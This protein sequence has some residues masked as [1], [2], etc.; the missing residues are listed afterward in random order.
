MHYLKDKGKAGNNNKIPDTVPGGPFAIL[1][2][3]L[4][5]EI[6]NQ[7][8]ANRVDDLPNQESE[9]CGLSF[10]DCYQKVER[11]TMWSGRKVLEPV[12]GGQIVEEV[13]HTVRVEGGG[14]EL[15]ELVLLEK[16]LVGCYVLVAGDAGSLGGLEV[17]F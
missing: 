9:G 14:C 10:C 12:R 2:V 5:R 16:L 8:S 17:I 3:K 1:R 13:T 11:E 7:R 4:I 15:V 6:S